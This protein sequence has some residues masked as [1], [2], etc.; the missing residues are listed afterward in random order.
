MTTKQLSE[1][2]SLDEMERIAKCCTQ[3]YFNL[4]GILIPS[5][6]NLIRAAHYKRP[7][8]Y[9]EKQINNYKINPAKLLH[10]LVG[11]QNL[12]DK[13]YSIDKLLKLAVECRGGENR[14]IDTTKETK[15]SGETGMSSRGGSIQPQQE[16]QKKKSNPFRQP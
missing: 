5:Y 8:E 11:L 10:V 7:D 13:K 4:T 16:E 1:N 3:I 6:D 2:F 9:I 14:I 15:G 12:L